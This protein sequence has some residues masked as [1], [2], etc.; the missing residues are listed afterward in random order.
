VTAFATTRP[1]VGV[2][3]DASS[4]GALPSLE[5]EINR[6]GMHVSFAVDGR[7]SQS[8]AGSIPAGDQAVPLLPGGGLVRWLGTRGLLHS[9]MTPMGSAHHHFYYASAGPSIGQWMLAHGAGGKRIGG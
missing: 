6:N 7:W 3:V 1:E 5:Q 4:V 9:W 8:V 2:I